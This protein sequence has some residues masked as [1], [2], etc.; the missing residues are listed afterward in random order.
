LELSK[1]VSAKVELANASKSS[2]PLQP[3]LATP[4]RVTAMH[5]Q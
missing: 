1:D 4:A 5:G 2:E 3:L